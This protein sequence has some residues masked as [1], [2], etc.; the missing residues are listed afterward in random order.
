M[1]KR[2]LSMLLVGLVTFTSAQTNIYAAGEENKVDSSKVYVINDSTYEDRNLIDAKE[3]LVIREGSFVLSLDEGIESVEGREKTYAPGELVTLRAVVKEG[4]NFN[5]WNH[6]TCDEL[7]YQF[8]MPEETPVYISAE[9]FENAETISSNI[10]VGWNLGNSLDS[11]NEKWEC[12]EDLHITQ[13]ISWG[14]PT[15]QQSL[16]DEVSRQGFNAIRIPVTWAYNCGRDSDGNLVIGKKW[17]ARVKKVVD[18]ANKNDMYVVLNSHHDEKLFNIGV[19]SDTFALCKKDAQDL[20]TQIA[21]EFKDYDEH[22]LFESYNEL[23][24]REL[25]ADG[26]DTEAWHDVTRYTKAGMV[27]LNE[28][29]EVFANAVRATGGNNKNRVLVLGSTYQ[30][31]RQIITKNINVPADETNNAFIYD[32][33]VYSTFEDQTYEEVLKP[34]VEFTDR[35]GAPVILGECGAMY[36]NATPKEHITYYA[37]NMVSRA[38]N[39][40][41]NCFWWDNGKLNEYGIFDRVN[42]KNSATEVSQALMK[43]LEL[44]GIEGNHITEI[45]DISTWIQGSISAAGEIN[46]KTTWSNYVMDYDGL[47]MEIPSDVQYASVY[48]NTRN[49]AWE[50]IVQYCAFYDADNNFISLSAIKSTGGRCEIPETA[51]YFRVFIIN[52][53]HYSK[54]SS[55]ANNY[56]HAGDLKL[57]ISFNKE[58][59]DCTSEYIVPQSISTH[60]TTAKS[61]NGIVIQNDE[62]IPL[63]EEVKQKADGYYQTVR[64]EEDSN[65]VYVFYANESGGAPE[66]GRISGANWVW[67]VNKNGKSSKLTIFA[68]DNN[69]TTWDVLCEDKPIYSNFKSVDSFYGFGLFDE[70]Y[71]FNSSQVIVQSE[72][73]HIV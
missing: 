49:N 15:I 67:G 52:R 46:K 24:N 69:C 44:K 31:G 12:G 29:N 8:V 73:H 48:L 56:F 61:N 19:A 5:G 30:G 36:K 72:W 21:E 10:T 4:Y 50:Y 58:K 70:K 39:K 27:Q 13:E 54:K 71:K 2:I 32:A 9:T 37:I 38:K 3:N 7:T 40:G 18:M 16:I 35:T 1:K 64:L 6:H 63:P 51:K 25:E 57:T 55:E 59:P 66:L 28:L 65:R 43:G 11:Y 42:L 14:N 47:G 33:H 60:K 53:Y 17:M 34:L 20:W 41:I 45:T 22:L 62:T 68:S 23:H 26:S